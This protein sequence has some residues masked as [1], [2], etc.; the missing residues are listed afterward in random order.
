M[1][2]NTKHI[3]MF[4]DAADDLGRIA[5]MVDN[6]GAV[7][8]LRNGQP[9]Y[10]MVAFEDVQ[11]AGGK[12]P[13]KKAKPETA[14]SGGAPKAS[15]GSNPSKDGAGKHGGHGGHGK[16]KHKC[17][18]GQNPGG[19]CEH[20]H[21]AGGGGCGGHGQGGQGNKA[22]DGRRAGGNAG[23]SGSGTGRMGGNWWFGADENAEGSPLPFPP[24]GFGGWHPAEGEGARA[25][26][27]GVRA[28]R[29]DPLADAFSHGK[30]DFLPPELN[31]IVPP[32]VME[33]GKHLV[34]RLM[35]IFGPPTT[36]AGEDE[37]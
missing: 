33:A 12:L 34:D 19:Y 3:V 9:A 6:D 24:F 22:G 37:K 17:T 4:D 27:D 31:D 23:A 14:A 2:V 28:E 16:G 30:P 5:D 25:E 7:L 29:V 26:R 10:V 32:D 18:C 13:G 1:L 21:G 35:G 15:S 20:D 11:E 8:M 36:G